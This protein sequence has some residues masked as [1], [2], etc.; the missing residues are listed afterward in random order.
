MQ[1]NIH[2]LG[3][4]ILIKSRAIERFNNT[5]FSKPAFLSYNQK[6]TRGLV[7]KL[8]ILFGTDLLII[9]RESKGITIVLQ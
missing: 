1:S 6:F 2:N 5:N 4:R 8:E 7:S 9:F 3:L